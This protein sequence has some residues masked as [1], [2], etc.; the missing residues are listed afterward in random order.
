MPKL[1]KRKLLKRKPQKRKLLR[2]KPQ[3]RSGLKRKLPKRSDLRKRLLRKSE[4][5]DSLE[6]KVELGM[7]RATARA[8]GE[9]E[10]SY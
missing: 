8:V 4:D 9:A 6:V 5:S 10:L 1:L 3:K 2:R 7:A